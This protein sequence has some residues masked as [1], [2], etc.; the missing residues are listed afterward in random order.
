MGKA[1]QKKHVPGGA[2][3]VAAN[4]LA[5][6]ETDTTQTFDTF[7]KDVVRQRCS[8]S[9]RDIQLQLV[10][11]G[12]VSVGLYPDRKHQDKDKHCITELL[13]YTKQRQR[14]FR[15]SNLEPRKQ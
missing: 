10:E 8:Q 11:F 7:L 5:L 9:L 15:L 1:L 3:K 12:Y 13:T 4:L 14:I 6:M 2:G